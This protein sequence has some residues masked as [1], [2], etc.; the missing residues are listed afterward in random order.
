MSTYEKPN[1]F[2]NKDDTTRLTDNLRNDSS[3]TSILT[4]VD[5]LCFFFLFSF[6][7]LLLSLLQTHVPLLGTS[8][9]PHTIQILPES[10]A[11][12]DSNLV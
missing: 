6:F 8:Y 12:A 11:L 9:N 4:L 2:A 10:L 3:E 7:P 5:G 1:V